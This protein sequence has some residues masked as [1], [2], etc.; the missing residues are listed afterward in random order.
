MI[1]PA[2]TTSTPCIRW[3][4]LRLLRYYAL[5]SFVDRPQGLSSHL[6][7]QINT[8]AHAFLPYAPEIY[9]SEP[10]NAWESVPPYKLPGG[11]GDH[12]W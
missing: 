6:I 10:A 1:A 8:A 2:G 3:L 11:S 9:P 7:P 12:R 4:E 5:R